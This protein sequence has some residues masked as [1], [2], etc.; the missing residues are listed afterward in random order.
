LSGHEVVVNCAGLAAPDAPIS[1]ELIGANAVLPLLLYRACLPAGVQRFVHVSSAAVQGR[2][3]VLDE[4]LDFDWRSPYARTK[5]LGE[6]ALVEHQSDSCQLLIYRATSVQSVERQIT[7]TLLRLAHLPRVPLVGDGGQPLPLAL[8]ETTADAIAHL[9]DA[10]KFGRINV[11]PWE[12]MTARRFFQLVNPAARFQRLPAST[13]PVGVELLWSLGTRFATAAAMA[14]RADLLAFGQRSV[15]SAMNSS[16]FVLRSGDQAY[17]DLGT[18]FR[19][20]MS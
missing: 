14:K 19:Q 17:A 5:G 4:S 9:V 8:R 2:R 3:P 13:T 10:Q 20:E 1:P 16:S 18:A 6:L 11:H 15:S 12:G 7:R